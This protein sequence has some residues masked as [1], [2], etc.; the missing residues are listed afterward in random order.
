MKI[1]IRNGEIYQ[2]GQ[3]VKKDILISN[4]KIEKI[5]DAI[6]AADADKVIDAEGQ[7]VLPGFI[8]LHAHLRDPG[9]VYKE[10]IVT[11]TKA[12]AK[13]GFTTVCAMPN[14]DPVVDSIA[15]VEYI[16]RK[17]ADLGSARVKIIGA[18]T[19]GSE[20]KEIALMS[21]MQE[22]G[23]VA[24]SDDGKCVQNAK[25]MQN[26]MKYAMNYNLPVITHPEDYNLAGKGQ[27]N[28][29]RYSTQLGL[30]AIPG[31]AEDI[32]VARDIMLARST[33][34]HLHVAHI[35]TARSIQMIR[36]AK[37]EGLKVTCEVTPHHL[38]MTDAK[39]VGF[40]TNFKVKPPLRGDKD[41]QAC[42]E[43]LIDGTIDY[44]ATD[45][46]PHADYEKEREFNLAPFGINGFEAAFASLYTEMV[47]T[48]TIPLNIIIEALT[49]KPAEFLKLK[50]G[51]LK[52]GFLADVIVVDLEKELLL[53]ID[54][55]LSKSKNTPYLGV[56][57]KGVV[58]STICNGRV[59][60]ELSN[61]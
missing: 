20:G 47:L 19:K 43:G 58:T 51:E 25:L 1:V 30:G 34:C 24:V 26:C 7:I 38:I 11:G 28:G 50:T 42:I 6:I 46:A 27:I 32:I 49:K 3:F 14:T 56:P 52:E 4:D 60:W 15:I 48:N 12:A 61:V 10:D 41:R 5:D 33:K 40:D 17:A 59:T 37:A 53:T 16:N 44:I 45:H 57:L 13:G 18:M 39:L 9:Q 35:S 22:G 29:G 36:E 31:L 8:D 2:A 55:M 21:T 23:I 54:N